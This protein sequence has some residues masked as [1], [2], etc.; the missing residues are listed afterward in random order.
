MDFRTP[1]EEDLIIIIVEYDVT[2]HEERDAATPLRV[3][4]LIFL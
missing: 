2:S 3:N 1:S 4:R